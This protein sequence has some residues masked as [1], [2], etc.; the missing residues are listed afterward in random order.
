MKQLIF[1]MSDTSLH[2]NRYPISSEYLAWKIRYDAVQMISHARASH[3][4]GVLSAA[5]LVAV[6]YCEIANITPQTV[7]APTRDRI[8]L[9]KGHNG[10]VIYATLAELGFFDREKLMTYG[11]NGSLLSC[12][13]SHKGLPGIELTTG[14]LGHGIGVAAGKALNGKIR[15]MPYHVYAIIGDGECDEGSVWEAALFSAQQKLDNFTVIIDRNRMQAMGH[16]DE[17]LCLDPFSE[18]WSSFGWNV[19]E[20]KNGHDHEELR[21]ALVDK[22]AG[23]PTVVIANTIK[24]KGISF[25]EDSLLWHYRDPHG[26][27]YTKA[28]QELQQTKPCEIM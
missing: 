6:L 15:K 2:G 7:S 13:I 23:M 16:T 21:K 1:S 18:K 17:V 28:M 11:D 24:G 3:I 27:Y 4:A 25:M 14:S 20:V 19:L 8:I 10:V 12:H 26:E 22:S 9:S 5:D